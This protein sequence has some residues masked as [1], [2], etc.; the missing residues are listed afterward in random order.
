[1]K[2]RICTFIRSNALWHTSNSINGFLEAV[3]IPI[4]TILNIHCPLVV[5][6]CSV[7]D[8]YRNTFVSMMHL[9]LDID[10]D[11]CKMLT[12]NEFFTRIALHYN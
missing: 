6:Q 9:F 12:A 10:Y 8:I 4:L 7:S 3:N 1:M 11:Y 2:A 5:Q